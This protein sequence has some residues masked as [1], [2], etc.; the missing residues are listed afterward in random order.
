METKV[1]TR[2]GQEKP[3]ADFIKN[4]KTK[5]GR[6]SQCKA[7]HNIVC[8]EYLSKKKAKLKYP[9]NIDSETVKQCE[10]NNLTNIPARLLISELRRRG[11]RGKLEL[12]TV[13]EVVI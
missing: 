12:V 7:C 8:K 11:Y 3:L 10:E 4:N 2:C 1:C 6:G 5:D 13:Q 9:V